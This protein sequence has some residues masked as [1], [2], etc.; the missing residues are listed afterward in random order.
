MRLAR[1]V[2]N[3]RGS[4]PDAIA[5]VQ[6]MTIHKAKGLE[7]DTVILPGLG[8]TVRGESRPALLW[9]QFLQPA[10]TP[11]GIGHSHPDERAV[12]LAPVNP[13]GDSTDPLY[14]W[15]WDLRRQQDLSESDRLLYVA[16]TRA[17]ESLHLFGQ[18]S[19]PRG[20]TAT[21]PA[22]SPA[23]GSLLERLWPV[24]SPHWPRATN[25][26][27]NLSPA[28]SEKTPNASSNTTEPHWQQPPLRRL[29]SGWRPA[30]PPDSLRL[31]VA[32]EPASMRDLLIYDWASAW[33]RHAGS[34]AHRFLQQIATDGAELYPPARI[35]A[36]SPHIRQLLLRQGIAIDA[37]E[38]GTERVVQV[39]TMALADQQGAWL[40]GN[41]SDPQNEWAITVLV[42][43]RFQRLVIDRAFVDRE[44]IRW[45]VDYKT[46]SHEGGNRDAFID[47]EVARYAPQLLAYREAVARLEQREI[48]T[49]LY[50]PLL[51]HLQLVSPDGSPA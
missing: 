22:D 45:I 38:Q 23:A 6:V 7:F 18:L 41:Q 4:L 9:Q 33:T 26:G 29:A 49:A 8:H 51:Q 24:V 10:S 46:G 3:A 35:Q 1:A 27:T 17:R 32:D 34:V 15:L 13:R 44:G 20:A 31:P 2:N 12:V 28:S 39:L 5:R 48:R 21:S 50:F 40:L 47:S 30:R 36:L 16:T 37:L 19:P 43:N 25:P 11:S 42:N 14:E